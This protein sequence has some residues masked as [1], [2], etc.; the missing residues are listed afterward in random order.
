MKLLPLPRLLLL[1]LLLQLPL[2][3]LLLLSSLGM[4]RFMVQTYPAILPI[5]RLQTLQRARRGAEAC[6]AP[7]PRTT[8][9][10]L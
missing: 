10:L 1:P 8:G 2:P 4:E 6:L 7:R 9:P 5:L 3:L